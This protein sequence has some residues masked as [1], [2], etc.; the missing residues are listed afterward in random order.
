[1]YWSRY[2]PDWLLPRIREAWN[3]ERLGPRGCILYN[4]ASSAALPNAL[5]LMSLRSRR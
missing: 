3:W 5:E 2:S 1:M 4:T